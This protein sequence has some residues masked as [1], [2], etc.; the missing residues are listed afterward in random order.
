MEVPMA[1]IKDVPKTW[2]RVSSWAFSKIL[3]SLPSISHYQSSRTKKVVRFHSPEVK[4]LIARRDQYKETM[5]AGSS[6]FVFVI[7][8]LHTCQWLILLFR[9]KRGFPKLSWESI[10]ALLPSPRCYKQ[11]RNFW[12][13]YFLWSTILGDSDSHALRQIVSIVSR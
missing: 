7:Y 13:F 10:N 2:V 4:K 5:E 9:I 11:A 3:E 6:L 8:A 12:Y 1:T